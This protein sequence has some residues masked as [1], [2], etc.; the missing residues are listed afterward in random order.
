MRRLDQL[1]SALL[2]YCQR[3][4]M[5]M[6]EVHPGSD[7]DWLASEWPRGA[8]KSEWSARFGWSKRRGKQRSSLLPSRC[9]RASAYGDM[10][11]VTPATSNV[12][13]I[14]P[15]RRPRLA[16]AGLPTAPV[17]SEFRGVAARPGAVSLRGAALRHTGGPATSF[18][19]A[20]VRLIAD[21]FCIQGAEVTVLSDHHYR[22][23]RRVPVPPRPLRS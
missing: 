17:W 1:R 18:Q 13:R 4:T 19:P 10:M 12:G 2:A 23:V 6:V 15:P 14:W 11:T 9:E 8:L 22:S 7:T 5:A 21:R 16:R 3:D 20:F